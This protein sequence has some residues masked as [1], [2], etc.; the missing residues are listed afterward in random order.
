[1]SLSS[2]RTT[3]LR[4]SS[5]FLTPTSPST[6]ALDHIASFRL[7]PLARLLIYS[8]SLSMSSTA[9]S[10]H[11]TTYPS[12]LPHSHQ[13][14]RACSRSH[15]LF[16]S[17]ASCEAAYLLD[18]LVNDLNSHIII[19]HNV[20]LS[21]LFRSLLSWLSGLGERGLF[22]PCASYHANTYFVRTLWNPWLPNPRTHRHFSRLSFS[23]SLVLQVRIQYLVVDC[24]S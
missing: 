9:A 3:F 19:H 2:E 22:F 4:L 14:V 24:P 6:L 1:M 21:D 13:P 5:C 23:P 7:Q 11:T 15:R 18:R 12:L 10:S 17:A 20:P 8:I 16:P